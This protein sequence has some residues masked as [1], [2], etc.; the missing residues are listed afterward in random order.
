MTNADKLAAF[1]VPWSTHVLSGFVERHPRFWRALGNLESFTLRDDIEKTPIDRPVYVAGLARAGTTI[2]L[3]LL[4]RHPDVATHQYRDFPGQFVPTWWNRGTHKKPSVPRERAHGDGLTVTEHSPEAMEEML[5]MAFFPHLHDPGH[6]NVLDANTC[7][8]SFE[9]FYRDH[10]RKLLLTRH[11]SRY[12]AKGNYNFTRFAYLQKLF[13]DATFVV[14]IRHPRNHIASLI[15]EQRL[16]C[17]GEAE[18]PR[19]LAHMRRV[20]HFEFGLDR[21]AINVGDGVAEQ[22][23][24]FWQKGE[25]VRGTARYWASLYNWLADSLEKNAELAAATLVVRYEDLCDDPQR[26]SDYLLSACELESSSE[27]NA[28]AE[29]IESPSYYQLDFSDEE[30]QIIAEESAEVAER[31]CYAPKLCGEP[32][33]L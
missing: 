28:F 8:A 4:S 16:F 11:R 21:R 15:K 31:F 26:A 5:W 32:L 27:V 9:T 17:A 19:A 7:H 2:L 1:Q 3:E 30:E 25:E 29:T 14:V 23:Q 6:K 13:P 24:S 20:G 33:L 12:V 18:Y 22:V 10:L